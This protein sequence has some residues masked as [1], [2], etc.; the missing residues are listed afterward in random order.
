MNCRLIK[1]EA[2]DKTTEYDLSTSGE[3]NDKGSGNMASL[4]VQVSSSC[5][6]PAALV[7]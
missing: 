2:F 7:S 5:V 3:I 6:S 1:Y 4:D